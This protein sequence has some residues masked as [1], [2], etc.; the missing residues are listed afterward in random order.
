MSNPIVFLLL[1]AAALLEA[2]GDS[3]F[4]TALHRARGFERVWWS[5]AG[6]LM[7]AGY[8][9]LVNGPRWDFGRLL[10]VYVVV[11]FLAAQAIAWLRFGETPGPP[12]LAGGALIVMGGAL[13]SF[14][15]A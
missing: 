5:L 15:R 2:G 10:G 1:A 12:L 8:G 11:F 13:I 14:W 3:C 4:Q 6:A 7:L 9:A